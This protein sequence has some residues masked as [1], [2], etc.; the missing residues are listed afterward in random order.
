[1]LKTLY[2]TVGV[3]GSGKSTFCKKLI[4]KQVSRDAIR[5]SMINDNDEYFQ[6]EKDVWK[7]YV[8]QIQEEINAN[9]TVIADATHL[10]K[11]SRQK[12]LNV[13]DLKDYVVFVL[14]FDVP[15]STCLARNTKRTGRENVP[16]NVVTDMYNHMTKPTLEED[17]RYYAILSINEEGLIYRLEQR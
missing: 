5:F 6:K 10:N 16:K 12:L 1:M 4:A 15:L 9:N 11:K 7:E 14:Y 8:H 17:D 13:L 3:P 2:L